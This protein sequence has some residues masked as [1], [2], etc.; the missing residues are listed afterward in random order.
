MGTVLSAFKCIVHKLGPR[1]LGTNKR[2]KCRNI[3]TGVAM[4]PSY[5][6]DNRKRFAAGITCS[7]PT[8]DVYHS[9]GPAPLVSHEVKDVAPSCTRKTSNLSTHPDLVDRMSPMYGNM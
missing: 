2:I 4:A 1:H 9:Q 6:N 7:I 8:E 3:V 5:A